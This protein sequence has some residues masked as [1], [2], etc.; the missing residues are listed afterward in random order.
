VELREGFRRRR[1][2]GFRQG[3]GPALVRVGGNWPGVE[4]MYCMYDTGR[5][6]RETVPYKPI[7]LFCIWVARVG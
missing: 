2:G 5:V 4:R 7:V 6:Y 3:G 1:K